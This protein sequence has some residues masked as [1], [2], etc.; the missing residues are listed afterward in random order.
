MKLHHRDKSRT[1]TK[2]VRLDTQKCQACW[3]CL[4]ACKNGVIGKIDL[5]I[6]KHAILRNP[7]SC[8]G[9]LKCVKVCEYGAYTR[10][11]AG[12]GTV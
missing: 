7:E 10:I 12:N 8:K 3:K 1:R 6:H 5:I 9:C 11:G 4:E 2:F